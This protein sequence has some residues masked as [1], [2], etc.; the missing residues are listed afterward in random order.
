MS[1]QKPSEIG[2]GQ[3]R[4]WVDSV[5][6][7]FEFAGCDVISLALAFDEVYVDGAN[8]GAHEERAALSSLIRLR[9]AAGQK[10][11]AILRM[12]DDSAAKRVPF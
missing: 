1:D 6:L 9:D 8:D 4:A 12:R 10:G 11:T 5:G 7:G 2:L 3:A